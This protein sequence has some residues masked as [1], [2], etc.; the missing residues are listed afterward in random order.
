VVEKDM[1]ILGLGCGGSLPPVL[2]PNCGMSLDL[3]DFYWFQFHPQFG[4]T[5]IASFSKTFHI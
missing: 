2:A 4:E 3:L 1:L 5:P